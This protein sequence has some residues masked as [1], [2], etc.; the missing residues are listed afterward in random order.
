[1]CPVSRDRFNSPKGI[2]SFR[3]ESD[4][5]SLLAAASASF[6]VVFSS[7]IV[8]G[9]CLPISHPNDLVCVV[10]HCAVSLSTSDKAAAFWRLLQSTR[11]TL[12]ILFWSGITLFISDYNSNC[13]SWRKMDCWRQ[14]LKRR[15]EVKVA[16][17]SGWF[18]R[19]NR[20]QLIRDT[21]EVQ[22]F[23]T[24]LSSASCRLETV[25]WFHAYAWAPPLVTLS[26]YCVLSF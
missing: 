21:L 22:R 13:W 3:K 9:D 10:A 5:L 18:F 15:G 24:S 23:R 4:S 2:I 14:M 26:A 16:V 7:L 1:M 20:A 25:G 17:S 12:I 6:F 8:A 11:M 19:Y